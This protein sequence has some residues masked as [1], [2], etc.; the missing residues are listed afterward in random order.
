MTHSLIAGGV[1]AHN[2]GEQGLPGWGV[3]N[4]SAV[5]L[6]KFYDAENHDVDWA[7][8][9]TTTRYSVRFLDNVIDKTPYH[10]PEK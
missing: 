10:F 8:L 3:C 1:V 4:L 5:N 7:D 9:A 6:S 2:C